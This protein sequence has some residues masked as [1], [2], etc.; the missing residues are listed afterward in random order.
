MSTNDNNLKEKS[1]RFA[2][3]IINLYKYLS[4]EKK[5]FVISKQMLRSGTSIGAN[6]REA[7]NAES[8]PDFIHK[9]GISQKETD[10][11]MYWIELLK[12]T[13]YLDEKQ[14]LSIYSESKELLKIIRSINLTTKNN[15][16]N[17][18]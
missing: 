13:D 18:S 9:L 14:F 10:E 8:K 2:V 1:F 4:H 5:E 17:N 15:L 12:E 7:Q 3:R 11:T 16:K 6:I